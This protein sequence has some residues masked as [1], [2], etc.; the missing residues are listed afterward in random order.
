MR[1][2]L[3]LFFVVALLQL[4]RLWW[5]PVPPPVRGWPNGYEDWK[6]MV[7]TL[8]LAAWLLRWPGREIE[9]AW[10]TLAVV[11]AGW[12]LVVMTRWVVDPNDLDSWLWVL[13]FSCA[14][15]WFL[16]PAM[17][18]RAERRRLN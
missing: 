4:V 10:G 15:A 9:V 16:L 11:N 6:C 18:E 7:M 1:K 5:W 12:L 17:L 2:C 8:A 14:A 13:G 3:I